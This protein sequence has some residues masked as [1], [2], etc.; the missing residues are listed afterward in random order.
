MNSQSTIPA[1]AQLIAACVCVHARTH[2]R[3]HAV[4]CNRSMHDK[5]DIQRNRI[6]LLNFFNNLFFN[7]NVIVATVATENKKLLILINL[8]TLIPV[9]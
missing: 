2:A 1:N 6:A 5:V 7:N 8:F 3:T 9:Q 4:H